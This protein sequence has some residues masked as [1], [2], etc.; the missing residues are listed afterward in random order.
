MNVMTN[1]WKQTIKKTQSLSM[2]DIQKVSSNRLLNKIKKHVQTIV[3]AVWNTDLKLLFS[4]TT[5]ILETLFITWHAVLYTF[6][7]ESCHM[8]SEPCINSF[9]DFIVIM[10]LPATKKGFQMLEKVIIAW[11]EVYTVQRVIRLFL[12]EGCEGMLHC[13]GSMWVGCV[14]NQHNAPGKHLTLLILDRMMQFF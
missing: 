8:W 11:C 1:F 6:V 7:I 13:S 3:V 5:F 4:H 2:R 14:M 9:F 12:S 10:E